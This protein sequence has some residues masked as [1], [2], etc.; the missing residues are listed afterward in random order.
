MKTASNVTRSTLDR[1]VSIARNLYGVAN[2]PQYGTFDKVRGSDAAFARID[3]QI[4]PEKP[5]DDP[6]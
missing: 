3:W 2:T 6:Q 5:A 1:F 4:N